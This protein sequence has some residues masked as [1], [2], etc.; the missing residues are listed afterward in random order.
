MSVYNFF[1]SAPTFVEE[2]VVYNTV[3]LLVDCLISSRDIRHQSLEL[4]EIALLIAGG[5]K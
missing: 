2:I 3:F 4:S 1:V 5:S